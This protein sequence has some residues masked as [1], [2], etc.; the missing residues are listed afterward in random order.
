MDNFYLLRPKL[1]RLKSPI[2]HRSTYP[3]M[4]WNMENQNERND[5]NERWL[6]QIALWQAELSDLL[7]QAEA[8]VSLIDLAKS[9]LKQD[10]PE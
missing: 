3:G 7:D 8:L 10:P 1:P 2:I 5:W 9:Q 4:M 6:R